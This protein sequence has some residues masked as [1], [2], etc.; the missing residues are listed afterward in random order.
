MNPSMKWLDD[1]RGTD[2]IREVARRVG[3]NQG[4][5]NRQVNLDQLTYE[6][7]R[8]VSRAYG[9]PVL[10]DLV[11]LGHLKA[12]D[13]GTSAIENALR[14]ATEEELVVELGRRLGI[15]GSVLFD[16]PMSQAIGTAEN[17]VHGRFG[18]DVGAPAENDQ[19]VARPRDPDNGED[20]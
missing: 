1:V 19:A 2:S 11:Q 5:L 12:T 3:M 7:V 6:T 20:T 18:N 9:R 16:A 14:A 4:T 13:L 17:V 8:D 15:S 10:A